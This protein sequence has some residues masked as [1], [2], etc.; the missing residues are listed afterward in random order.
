M[1]G[2]SAYPSDFL[3]DQLQDTA[4]KTYANPE[5][6]DPIA[7]SYVAMARYGYVAVEAFFDQSSHLYSATQTSSSSGTQ[8]ALEV[9]GPLVKP[10]G[11]EIAIRGQSLEDILIRR[12]IH[13]K[14]NPIFSRVLGGMA[15]SRRNPTS[16][17]YEVMAANTEDFKGQHGSQWAELATFSSRIRQPYRGDLAANSQL[18]RSLIVVGSLANANNMLEIPQPEQV[19]GDYFASIDDHTA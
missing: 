2:N 13:K 3:V 11:M 6:S 16:I 9:R 10:Q 5:L 18:S 17:L 8:V 14:T 19:V 15:F 1:R 12:I 4:S 7:R